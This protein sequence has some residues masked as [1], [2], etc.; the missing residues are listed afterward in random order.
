MLDVLPLE[1][2]DE[3]LQLRSC[4]VRLAVAGDKVNLTRLRFDEFHERAGDRLLSLERLKLRLRLTHHHLH[5]VR[6]LELR[7]VRGVHELILPVVIQDHDVLVRAELILRLEFLGAGQVRKRIDDL[8]VEL[9]ARRILVFLQQPLHVR[10]NLRRAIK[11]DDCFHRFLKGG[12]Q[13]LCLS[14]ELEL[15]VA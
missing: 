3:G 8:G 4:H 15:S 13:A 11:E 2:F 14:G 1:S 5:L 6:H 10:V 12:E 7:H 9:L